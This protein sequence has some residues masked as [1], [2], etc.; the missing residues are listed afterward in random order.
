MS[1]GNKMNPLLY[2]NQIFAMLSL[3]YY[4]GRDVSS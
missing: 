4:V 3:D 2:F 1:G